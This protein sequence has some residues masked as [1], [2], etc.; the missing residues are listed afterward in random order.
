MSE[1]RSTPCIVSEISHGEK[2]PSVRSWRALRLISALQESQ[3]DMAQHGDENNSP[4]GNRN[5]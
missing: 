4:H 3:Q 5:P 1:M 2:G